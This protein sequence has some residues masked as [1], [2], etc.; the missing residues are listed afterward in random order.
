MYDIFFAIYDNEAAKAH[1][2]SR[3]PLAKF[4][5]VDDNNSVQDALFS[6]QKRSMTKMFWFVNPDQEIVDGF[7]FDYKVS[8]WDQ[9][10][11][12]VFVDNTVFLIPKAYCI[13]EKEASSRFFVNKKDVDLKVSYPRPVDIFFAIYDVEETKISVLE[14]FPNAKFCYVKENTSIGDL[15]Y[16]A[17]KNA[18]TEMFWF[19]DFDYE[20]NENFDLNYDVPKWDQ[21][22]VHVFQEQVT[23]TFAGAYLIPKAYRI[24]KK[25]AEHVFFINKKEISTVVCG[26]KQNDIF[27]AI[28]DVEETKQEILSRYPTAKFCYIDQ[29]RTTQHVLYEAQQRSSTEIFWFVDFS[30]QLNEDFDLNFDV[31]DW[32]QEYV[33]VFTDSN[34]FLIP[35]F[36]PTTK[37]EADHLFFV[38]KKEIDTKI[39]DKKQNDIF[40]AIYDVKEERDEILSRYPTAK[41]CYINQDHSVQHA[42]YEAQQRSSTEMFW[43]VHVDYYVTDDFNFKLDV[44]NW[45]QEYVHVFKDSTGNYGGVFLIPKFY[46]I[47]KKEAD[48]LFFVNKKEID[49]HIV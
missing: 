2:K 42:L 8:E 40:F 15:L 9:K 12:H 20:L 35:K 7:D 24:A 36:Y 32:D 19:V 41:F 3:F 23:N 37:K 33:H 1:I 26:K 16:D 4:C 13:T 34:A 38:N 30:H 29:E 39:T 5:I 11:A 27:F 25:E 46:P 45:D 44:P 10:Y 48:Y 49:V 18:L 22:Y 14:R 43:F 21:Q 17:Q 47:T 31:P 6:A 28:Y